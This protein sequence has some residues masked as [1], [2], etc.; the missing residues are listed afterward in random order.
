VE[1]ISCRRGIPERSQFSAPVYAHGPTA[2]DRRIRR[3]IGADYV[4]ATRSAKRRTAKKAG[5]RFPPGRLSVYCLGSGNWGTSRLSPGYL[6]PGYCHSPSVPG[7]IPPGYS[8]VCPRVI[9]G[10]FPPGYSGLF[11]PGLFLLET[12]RLSP[13]FPVPGFSQSFACDA[14]GGVFGQAGVEDGVGNLVGDFIGMAFGH[15]FRG[16]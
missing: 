1:R 11:V 14:A 6:S 9:P 16:K 7:L 4:A 10:L 15:R 2:G 12:S 5:D 13:V 8:R 3:G